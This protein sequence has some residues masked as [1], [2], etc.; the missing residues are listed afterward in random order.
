MKNVCFI[1]LF[2]TAR[3][4]VLTVNSAMILLIGAGHATKVLNILS[5]ALCLCHGGRAPCSRSLNCK[6]KKN[7]FK[8]LF[9]GRKPTLC[10]FNICFSYLRIFIFSFVGNGWKELIISNGIMLLLLHQ[11]NLFQ[12]RSET[13]WIQLQFGW[14]FKSTEYF[15]S[16]SYRLIYSCLFL[17]WLIR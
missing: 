5:V 1:C 7:I 4:Q 13:S 10:C 12:F 3:Q 8:F 15:L 2:W 6:K 17:C 9:K 14:C 11:E 16:F